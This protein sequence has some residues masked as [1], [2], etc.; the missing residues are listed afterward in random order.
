MSVVLRIIK[1]IQKKGIIGFLGA[2]IADFFSILDHY[3]KNFRD[4]STKYKFTDK[5]KG[6]SNLIVVLAGYKSYLWNFTLKNIYQYQLENADVCIVSAGLY[7]QE[8]AD[9]CDK[10]GWS[11]LSVKRNSPG[12]ALNKAILLHPESDYIY[13]LDEDIFI[14]EKFFE[15]LKK[16]YDLTFKKT[17]LEPGFVAPVL[18]INGISYSI[19]LK[20][21]D[22]EKEYKERFGDIIKRC[23]DLP[24]HNNPETAWWLWKNSLPFYD[25]SKK[26]S[27]NQFDYSI[28][29]TR[30]SIGAILF[31][32]AFIE[33]V[34]GF[35]S[36]WH[37][38]VLGVDEDELCRDCT[39]HSRPIYLMHNI[40]AGHF[41][42]YP[43]ESYMK[44]KLPEMA[45]LDPRTFY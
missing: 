10:N 28:C 14:S 26:I 4:K 22:L 18:N 6:Q 33:Q 2:G 38:G 30:F 3:L 7:S 34:G 8:L 17:L 19:F 29:N 44:E 41:S 9:L 31:R 27:D 13:K 16:G 25:I 15:N 11:Y 39:S 24:V 37:S 42:F 45:I 1:A 32:R 5:S 40:L 43:Q 21:L 20:E 12:V 36:A 23:G 35:K